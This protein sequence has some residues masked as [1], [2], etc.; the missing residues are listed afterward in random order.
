M[1]FEKI[2]FP[3]PAFSEAP[4]TAIDCGLKKIF[5]ESKDKNDEDVI[6]IVSQKHGYMYSCY[7][8]IKIYSIIQT[9]SLLICT[10]L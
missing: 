5:F 10:F 1:I 7:D 9:I 4:I 6:I 2:A 8:Y 3:T